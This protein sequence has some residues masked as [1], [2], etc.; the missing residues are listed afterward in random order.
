VVSITPRPSCPKERAPD[1]IYFIGGWE[2]ST[3]G[4]NTVETRH[5]FYLCREPTLFAIRELLRVEWDDS[6]LKHIYIY[7]YIYTHT[8]KVNITGNEPFVL[9]QD[10][11]P[12]YML[13]R[14]LSRNTS[15][16]RG[17]NQRLPEDTFSCSS[18]FGVEWNWVHYYSGHYWPVVPAPDD[19]GVWRDRS[20]DWKEKPKYSEKTSHSVALSTTNTTWP[21]PG[22]NPCRRGGK[23]AD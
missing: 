1:T 12:A 8:H 2:G 13:V 17:M 4:L 23:P 16:N 15:F 14:S 3:T 20:N 5:I 11:D 9:F 7:I 10:T 19:D 22:S 6:Y 18:L 21:D